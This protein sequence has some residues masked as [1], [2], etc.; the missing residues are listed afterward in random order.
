MVNNMNETTIEERYEMID[1]IAT[2]KT[3]ITIREEVEDNGEEVDVDDGGDY[4]WLYYYRLW[5][6]EIDQWSDADRIRYLEEIQK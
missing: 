4:N 3:N 1:K 5:R 2:Y 6:Q